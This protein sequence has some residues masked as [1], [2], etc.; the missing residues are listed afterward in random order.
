MLI[1]SIDRPEDSLGGGVLYGPA[2]TGP[3]IPSGQ[4]GIL[5]QESGV[6]SDIIALVQ[7]IGVVLSNIV[8]SLYHLYFIT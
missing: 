5:P 6:G 3:T 4:G 2:V 1:E 8:C 7:G